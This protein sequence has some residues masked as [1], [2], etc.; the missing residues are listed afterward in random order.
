MLGFTIVMGLTAAGC[1]VLGYWTRTRTDEDRMEQY[2]IEQESKQYT[3]L[4]EEDY[5]YE[6][7]IDTVK[8][9]V[10][11][12][13]FEDDVRTFVRECYQMYGQEPNKA[14]LRA[15][16]TLVIGDCEFFM[17]MNDIQLWNPRKLNLNDNEQR[18]IRRIWVSVQQ[19]D[20]SIKD[21]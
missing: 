12:F 19:R 11:D 15:S 9:D 5:A 18:L 16:H 3:D 20:L 14:V 6:S 1:Y 2:R 13:D 4:V 7:M 17:L 8:D 10:W 21:L